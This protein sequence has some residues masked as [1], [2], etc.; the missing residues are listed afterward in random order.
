M[1]ASS[2]V[3]G[4]SIVMVESMGSQATGTSPLVL[5]ALICFTT[6]RISLSSK[7]VAT[8]QDS[9]GQ[10]P[11]FD[12]SDLLEDPEQVGRNRANELRQRDLADTRRLQEISTQLIQGDVV[13]ALYERIL[14]GAVG[15]MRAD[16]ASIQIL[17][18]E[19]TEGRGECVLLAPRGL[20]PEAAAAWKTGR[21]S[22]IC[23]GLTCMCVR[24]RTSLNA[25][26]Q[27]KRPGVP[28]FGTVRIENELFR[29]AT[30]DIRPAA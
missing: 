25:A 2:D 7:R 19:R 9:I 29:Q 5:R 16:F 1:A 14:D 13:Q 6:N 20:T 10:P 15:I 11:S 21:Q 30:A 18:S 22:W 17:I 26:G 23:A 3:G 28:V 24:R 4:R 27:R 8:G 12:R